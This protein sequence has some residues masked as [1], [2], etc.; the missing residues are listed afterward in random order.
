MGCNCSNHKF[1]APTP[2]QIVKGVVGA[3]KIILGT[4]NASADT[5]KER[6]D[7]CRVCEFSTKNT[8]LINEPCKGLTS[9]SQCEKCACFIKYKTMLQDSQCPQNK[10]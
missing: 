6:R 1:V 5:I 3:A 2:K 7:I 10:W 4:N 8:A 9:Y